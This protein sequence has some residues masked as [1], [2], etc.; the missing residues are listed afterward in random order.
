M[1][2][3]PF[4]LPTSL[5]VVLFAAPLLAV[6]SG[7]DRGDSGCYDRSESHVRIA[8]T[9]TEAAL[10]PEGEALTGS[11][12]EWGA[13]EVV[14][15]VDGAPPVGFTLELEESATLPD[16]SLDAV[17]P[18]TLTGWGFEGASNRPTEPTIEVRT[19]EGDL[20]FILGTAEWAPEGSS[21]SVMAPRDMDSCTAYVHDQGQARNK[22]AYISFEDETARLFQGDTTT[23]G[24]LDVRVLSAQS[25]NRSHPWAP[26]A[27][28]DC[29]WEKLSWMAFDPT[30]DFIAP[31]P[32]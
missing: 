1:S 18:I 2:T 26:C 23:L 24:G 9:A 7:C 19:E 31:P 6:M 20:L 17:G 15:A 4:T 16:L 22:P 21:W 30:L 10:P 12:A 29:P 13:S 5:L 27:T 11:F 32:G 8:T 14:F 3:L 28:A 25:N